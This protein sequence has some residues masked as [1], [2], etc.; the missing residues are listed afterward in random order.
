MKYTLEW[1]KSEFNRGNKIKYE[2]FWGHR[3][4]KNGRI[5]KSCF[6]QWW[7]S[8]FEI[9]NIVYCCAEQYMMAEKARL[10][11]DEEVLEEILK[12]K[13]Q[14]KIKALGRKVKNFNEEVW[15]KNKYDIVLRGN[16]AKFSQNEALK[17][18]LLTTGNKVLVEASPYDRVWGI[19]LSADIEGIEN[20][21]LWKGENFLGFAL[22]EVRD[23]LK[24]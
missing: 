21:L 11:N 18:Y 5:T 6:S 12:T 9:D 4:S 1:V 8:E 20:P 3:P 2:F 13:E 19:G 15:N 14:G 10:F 23:I 16:K 17:E 22:M 7:M 24:G